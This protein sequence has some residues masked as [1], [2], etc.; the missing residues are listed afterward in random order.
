MK[1]PLT[2]QNA[3]SREYIKNKKAIDFAIQKVLS[4]GRYILGKELERF[5]KNFAEYLGVKYVVGV[6]NGFDA[7][8]LSL[9]VAPPGKVLIV[10][11]LHISVENACKFTFRPYTIIKPKQF[12]RSC[13]YIYLT[14]FLIQDACRTIGNLP[15]KSICVGDLNCFSFHPLKKL[16]C[17]GDGGA[18]AT[19]HKDLY[20]KLLILR[21]HGRIGK[22]FRY[23]AGVN[24]RLDEIQA[25]VLNVML[26]RGIKCGY[27]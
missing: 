10:N 8:Y 5:E 21:N 22:T 11:P 7:L 24:S 13:M 1:S 15:A 16:H 9:L 25:A 18:I 27:L 14:N 23:Q 6:G 4:S 17:Y 19:N 2:I 26:E 20:K 12:N 3:L